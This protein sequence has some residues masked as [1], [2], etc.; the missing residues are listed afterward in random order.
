ME[1]AVARSEHTGKGFI[2]FNVIFLD[3]FS[4]F[5]RDAKIFLCQ[6]TKNKGFKNALNPQNFLQPI[7][8]VVFHAFITDCLAVQESVSEG[9]TR[10]H[11]ITKP[12]AKLRWLSP[13]CEEAGR[14]GA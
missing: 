4:C 12:A 3:I 2:S 9:A 10:L 13:P 1:L 8:F 11:K 14:G 6:K 5:L 7:K